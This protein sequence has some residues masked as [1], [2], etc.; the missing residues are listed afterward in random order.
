[1]LDDDHSIPFVLEFVLYNKV[2]GIG[3]KAL[4]GLEKGLLVN[5]M[6]LLH[7]APG[8]GF[9]SSHLYCSIMGMEFINSKGIGQDLDFFKC[10]TG[11]LQIQRLILRFLLGKRVFIL[12]L[13]H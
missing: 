13:G 5:G 4:S 3:Y 1:M 11:G 10:N 8:S 6:D 7:R 2:P 9:V 12:P